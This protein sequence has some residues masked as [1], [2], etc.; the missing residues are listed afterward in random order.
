MIRLLLSATAMLCAG[1]AAALSC[2][3]PDPVRSFLSA[4]EAEEEYAVLHGTFTFD[5]GAMPDGTLSHAPE[6]FEPSLVVAQFSG[7]ILTPEGFTREYDGPIG[8]Q[9]TCAGPWCGRLD[10]PVTALAFARVLDLGASVTLDPCNSNVFPDPGR[11]V[12]TRIVACIQ[13][14]TCEPE[15]RP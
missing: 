13:G 15:T 5:D 9:P 6:G 8:L 12:L 4:A 11:E 1:Q 14:D 2:M 10:S 7:N 3:P